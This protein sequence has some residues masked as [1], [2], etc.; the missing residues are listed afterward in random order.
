M[1]KRYSNNSVFL[2]ALICILVF[3]S[4][5]I[6]LQD[7]NRFYSLIP[8]GQVEFLSGQMI[9]SPGKTSNGKYYSGKLKVWTSGSNSVKSSASGNVKVF[10]PCELAEVYF[11]GKLYSAAKGAFFEAGGLYSLKGHF[12]GDGQSFYVDSCLSST[13]PKTFYGRLDYFRA[14][15]RLQFKRLMYS[16]G[17]AG[18][19][20]L[21]LLCG[22]K[23]YTSSEVSSS[24]KNAGLSHILAL[25]GMH[26][27]MFSGIALFA[28]KKIGRK[29]L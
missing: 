22:A 27:S 13:F 17:S 15:C 26:L 9:S 29:K 24:F 6:K 12:S 23:E 11:P 21:A 14:L 18:G 7:R 2:A 8:C 25:S 19:L 1:V 4:G 10:I 20:L 28:G 5:L 3:Y 16:W